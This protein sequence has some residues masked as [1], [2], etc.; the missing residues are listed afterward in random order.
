MLVVFKIK[1]QET[2]EMSSLWC[3]CDVQHSAA[4]TCTMRG[5]ATLTD[6]R[7][8]L[9]SSL[10]LLKNLPST[11]SKTRRDVEKTTALMFDLGHTV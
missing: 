9:S 7:I 4:H 3:G 1:R 2:L 10:D 6:N 8:I 5:S 11:G